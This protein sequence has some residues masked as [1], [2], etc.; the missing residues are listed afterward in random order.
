MNR[1]CDLILSTFAI[2]I[3]FPFWIVITL[4]ILIFSPGS[5]FF[6]HERIGRNGSRFGLIKFRTMKTN[7]SGPQVTVAGDSRVTSIGRVLRALKLDELPQLLNVFVGQM[8]IVGPRPEA[9][10]YVHRYSSGQK[11]ILDYR[12]GLVDPATL[13]YR[14]EEEI[15]AGY[16]NPQEAYLNNILPDKI[17]ISL[18]YQKKRNLLTDL[19]IIFKTIAAIFRG[20]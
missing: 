15:L 19:G 17:E 16:D 8:A 4:L 12:P 13:K 5:P 6:V 2:I 7:N 1:F 9:P 3:T 10:E 11:R 20:R 18:E 14:D